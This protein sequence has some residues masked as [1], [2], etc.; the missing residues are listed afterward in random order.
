MNGRSAK[1]TLYSQARST[2]FGKYII[3]LLR[4][5]VTF[6]TDPGAR[7]LSIHTRGALARNTPDRNQIPLASETGFSSLYMGLGKTTP[8]ENDSQDERTSRLLVFDQWETR[9][10]RKSAAAKFWESFSQFCEELWESA[11]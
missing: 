6:S 1:A 3:Q 5:T 7:A 9:G 8:E 4:F 10:R 11:G 2:S